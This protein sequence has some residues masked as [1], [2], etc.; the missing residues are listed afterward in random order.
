MLDVETGGLEPKTDRLL[1]VGLHHPFSRRSLEFYVLGPGRVT[2]EALHANNLDLNV[3]EAQGLAPADACREV[4]DFL[5][6]VASPGG[7]GARLRFCGHNVAFDVAF[8]RELFALEGKKLPGVLGYNRMLCTSSLLYAEI[9]RGN[10]PQSCSSLD[11]AASH[12]KIPIPSG[13][14]TALVDAK[15]AFAVLSNLL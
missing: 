9:L 10:L 2:D 11:N 4:E 7:E 14:H 1:Q 13:R 15:L 12:F 5:V 3:V 8:L 6:R